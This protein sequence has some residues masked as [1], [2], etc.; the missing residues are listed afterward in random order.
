MMTFKRLL[1]SLREF[2]VVGQFE[3][4]ASLDRRSRRAAQWSSSALQPP[5]RI[6]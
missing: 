2:L 1:N 6:P 4:S 5:G 3:I